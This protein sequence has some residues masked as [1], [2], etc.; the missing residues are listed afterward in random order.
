MSSFP[1]AAGYCCDDDSNALCTICS[2]AGDGSAATAGTAVAERMPASSAG[3][4]HLR[5]DACG[6]FAMH[7]RSLRVV[8]GC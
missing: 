4:R 3:A 8:E 5:T 1:T 6:A 7:F 2:A